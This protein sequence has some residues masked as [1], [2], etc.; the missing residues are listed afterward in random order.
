MARG[1]ARPNR[2]DTEKVLCC[3]RPMYLVIIFARLVSFVPM[4]L[5][6]EPNLDSAARRVSAEGETRIN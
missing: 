1:G 3:T 6:E 4:H 5:R 2:V